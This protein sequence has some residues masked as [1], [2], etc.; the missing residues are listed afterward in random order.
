MTWIM[1]EIW[2]QKQVNADSGVAVEF[3]F[4]VEEWFRRH[5]HIEEEFI[6]QGIREQQ[7]GRYREECEKLGVF[8]DGEVVEGS[9][10][11]AGFWE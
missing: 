8:D 11:V 10:Q 7:I 5:P 6:D 3:D 4:V 9:D 2:R 1:C